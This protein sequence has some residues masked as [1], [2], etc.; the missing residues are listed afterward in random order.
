VTEHVDVFLAA[1]QMFFVS[2]Q[3]GH[4]ENIPK[5]RANLV[6]PF[7]NRSVGENAVES[8]IDL[9]RSKPLRVIIKPAG[10]GQLHRIEVASPVIVSPTGCADVK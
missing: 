1:C 10:P 9:D 5:V 8:G 2:D 3:P 4:F 6:S 7:F